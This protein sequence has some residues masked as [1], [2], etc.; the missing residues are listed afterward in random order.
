MK[1]QQLIK[2]RKKDELWGFPVHTSNHTH[3]LG[4]YVFPQEEVLFRGIVK[5]QCENLCWHA[6]V[7]Q[8][9]NFI[10]KLPT[11]EIHSPVAPTAWCQLPSCSN[12]HP[13][14]LPSINTQHSGL[15][16]SLHDAR[17]LKMSPNLIT[18]GTVSH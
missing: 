1:C 16:S 9:H 3:T 15:K 10:R 17:V 6:I 2:K 14:P 18:S 7:L 12:P 5:Y 13:H 11:C 8:L 4:P